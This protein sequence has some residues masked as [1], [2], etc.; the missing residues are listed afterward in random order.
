M[1]VNVNDELDFE[2][3]YFFIT[4]VNEK[5]LLDKLNDKNDA[6]NNNYAINKNERDKCIDTKIYK[7]HNKLN[8]PRTIGVNKNYFIEEVSFDSSEYVDNIYKSYKMNWNNIYSH[9]VND[10]NRQTI[11][12][13][14]KIIHKRETFEIFANRFQKYWFD[15]ENNLNYKVLLIM[16]TTQ[17][18]FYFMFLYSQT[19]ENKIRKLYNNPHL[20]IVN[21]DHKTIHFETCIDNEIKFIAILTLFVKDTNNDKKILNLIRLELNIIFNLIGYYTKLFTNLVN[22]LSFNTN[23]RDITP[24]ILTI[25]I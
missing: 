19:F 5:I 16:L 6:I 3:D 2:K 17:A 24:G 20:Y 14:N 21:G 12:I 10:F 25:Q 4:V 15:Q 13:D 9:Y 23:N 7:K 22:L 1:N 18:S 8:L 11:L